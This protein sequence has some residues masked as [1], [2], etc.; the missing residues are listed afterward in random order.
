MEYIRKRG[1]GLD[2]LELKGKENVILIGLHGRGSSPEDFASMAELI[3]PDFSYIFPRAPFRFLNGYEWY[4][5]DERQEQSIVR[6]TEF[7]DRFFSDLQEN[8]QI[9]K[10]KIILFGFSQGAVMTFHYG[11]Q[12]PNLFSGLIGMSGY[13][14]KPE[15]LSKLI[16]K[17]SG[18]VPVLIIHGNKDEVITVPFMIGKEIED[19]LKKLGIDAEFLEFDMGHE[20]TVDSLDAMRGW[21]EGRILQR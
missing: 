1:A 3:S 5:F 16:P 9:S 12:H 14:Y 19:Y 2:Y 7:L 17:E 13:I 18:R 15:K 4:H 10:R 8:Y 20:A 21:I 6:S 11:L